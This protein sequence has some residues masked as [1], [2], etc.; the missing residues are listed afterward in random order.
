MARMGE[1]MTQVGMPQC[2]KTEL[3]S[4]Q[5]DMRASQDSEIRT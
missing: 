3:A 5:I 1:T 2:C 4:F